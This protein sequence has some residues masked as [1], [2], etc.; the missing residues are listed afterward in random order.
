MHLVKMY[1][2]TLPNLVNIFLFIKQAVF[3]G[4]K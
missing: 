4:K 2:L 3:D 1:D